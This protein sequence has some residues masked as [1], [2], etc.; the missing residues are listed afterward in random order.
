MTKDQYRFRYLRSCMVILSAFELFD[1]WI[2]VF[3][4]PILKPYSNVCNYIFVESLANMFSYILSLK[5]VCIW[6][7]VSVSISILKFYYLNHL[8]VPGYFQCNLWM[9]VL[10]CIC[11]CMC[12]FA[13]LFDKRHRKCLL[14]LVRLIIQLFASLR[15]K[16]NCLINLHTY[17]H[18]CFQSPDFKTSTLLSFIVNIPHLTSL[19]LIC[20]HLSSV[21]SDIETI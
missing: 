3:I 18:W 4:Y 9:N 6:L 20:V 7:Y 12:L 5:C 19:L 14:F 11:A 10:T 1:M 8:C 21:L 15:F 17:R 16:I 13:A 2:W